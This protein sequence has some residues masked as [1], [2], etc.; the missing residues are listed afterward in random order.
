MWLKGFAR[1]DFKKPSSPA[2]HVGHKY[3]VRIVISIR[4][5]KGPARAFTSPQLSDWLGPY[6][7]LSACL[8]LH[9]ESYDDEWLCLHHIMIPLTPGII[10]TDDDNDS[11]TEPPG[12][13]GRRDGHMSFRMYCMGMALLGWS[14]GFKSPSW[15]RTCHS[16]RTRN[17]NTYVPK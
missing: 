10:T 4:L 3:L 8:G 14:P 2:L 1:G 6:D 5:Y 9:K 15:V 13:N 11:G 16:V 7:S 12:I 17:L